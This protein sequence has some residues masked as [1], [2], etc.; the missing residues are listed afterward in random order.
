M[1]IGIQRLLIGLSLGG[2]VL[3]GFAASAPA[4]SPQ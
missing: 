2:C 1:K 3:V 4:A